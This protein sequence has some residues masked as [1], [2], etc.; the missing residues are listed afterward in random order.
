MRVGLGQART[1]D[2]ADAQMVALGFVAAQPGLDLAQARRAAKL[3][4]KQCRKLGFCPQP[5]LLAIGAVDFDQ[6]VKLAPRQ[7]LQHRVQ[8]AILMAHGTAPLCVQNV[9]QRPNANR[10]SAVRTV[11][12]KMC[13]TAVGRAR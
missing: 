6:P 10:Y 11:K 4:I 5:A 7:M 1:A 13:R 3:G 12:H 2:P 8:H 9:P